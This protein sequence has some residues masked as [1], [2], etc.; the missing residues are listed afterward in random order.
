M[1]GLVFSTLGRRPEEGDFVT[2]DGI[3]LA[4]DEL[5]GLRITRLRVAPVTPPG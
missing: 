1:A 3:R 5:D 4:V 2:L